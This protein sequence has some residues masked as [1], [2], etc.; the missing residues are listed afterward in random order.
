MPDRGVE[1][2]QAAGKF[3]NITCH[4]SGMQHTSNPAGTPGTLS[5]A[6]RTRCKQ[7]GPSCHILTAIMT[8]LLRDSAESDR[9]VFRMSASTVCQ[10]EECL[11]F[12]P[13]L[14]TPAHIPGKIPAATRFNLI[15]ASDCIVEYPPSGA[16]SCTCGFILCHCC[17]GNVSAPASTAIRG[18]VQLTGEPIF[19]NFM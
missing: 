10:P 1:L 11:A 9:V 19:L 13:R 16:R 15:Y 3:A 6:M 2:E 18:P 4:N 14:D 7:P 8:L 5:A 17:P 12:S